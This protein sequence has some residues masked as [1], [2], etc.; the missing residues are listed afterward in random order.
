[1]SL[2]PIRMAA[3]NEPQIEPKP[4][5]RHHDQ[6][7]D[8]IDQREGRIEADDLDR[9]RAAEPGKSGAER[10]GEREGA[11]DI[12]A[13]TA[14]H[15]LVVDRG[16]HLLAEAGEFERQH[17]HQRHRKPDRH[18]EQAIDPESDAEIVDRTAQEQRRRRGLQD[19]SEDIG[20]GSR[21]T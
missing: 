11:V 16:A 21:S 3:T 10:E 20:R 13:E 6:H 14:R 4:A 8:Q 9:K 17:Q 5:D 19:G 7:I 15:A 18:Q 2:T 12:D 1:M